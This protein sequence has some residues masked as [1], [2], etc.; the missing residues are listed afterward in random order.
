[1]EAHQS[2]WKLLQ[3]FPHCAVT[4]YGDNLNV[5]RI[6]TQWTNVSQAVN[7]YKAI[8]KLTSV[9]EMVWQKSQQRTRRAFKKFISFTSKLLFSASRNYHQ[10]GSLGFST[11]KDLRQMKARSSFEARQSGNEK[12]CNFGTF[13]KKTRNSVLVEKEEKSSQLLFVSISEE[14]FLVLITFDHATRPRK[15]KTTKTFFG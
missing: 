11:S 4:L 1:M 2:K 5:V 6:G 7:Y 3:I 10:K 9:F 12:S 8:N 14:P 15:S 13:E